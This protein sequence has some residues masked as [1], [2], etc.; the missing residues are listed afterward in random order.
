MNNYAKTSLSYSTQLLCVADSDV[1]IPADKKLGF[2]TAT[3]AEA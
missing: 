3:P 2:T 1:F